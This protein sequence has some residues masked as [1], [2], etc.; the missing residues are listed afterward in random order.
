[1]TGRFTI[2]CTIFAEQKGKHGKNTIVLVGYYKS[3]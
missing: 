2:Y 3:M 1:M